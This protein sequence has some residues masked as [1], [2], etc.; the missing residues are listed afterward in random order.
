MCNTLIFYHIVSYAAVSFPVETDAL[1]HGFS[2]TFFSTLY[3]SVELSTVPESHT[4][5]MHSW[6]PLFI[7]LSNPVTLRPGD[8][9]TIH[10]WR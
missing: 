7:P 8:T 6:F 9:V 10:I 5:D 4:H 2:G 3:S 1:L